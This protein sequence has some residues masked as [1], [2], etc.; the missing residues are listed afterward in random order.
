MHHLIR[1][2]RPANSPFDFIH[3]LNWLDWNRTRFE[4][5]NQ[6]LVG[7]WWQELVLFFRLTL[8]L[9]QKVDVPPSVCVCVCARVFSSYQPLP[10]LAISPNFHCLS[11][12]S[13]SNRLGDS[14][15]V[16]KQHSIANDA[17][18][19]QNS[20]SVDQSAQMWK[21]NDENISQYF[22]WGKCK[23]RF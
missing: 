15:A 13:P 23:I 8:F 3:I 20:E 17:C 7:S 6:R 16:A 5:F 12:F 4:Q 22:D 10:N 11:V 21:W 19:D 9:I 14:V 18:I 1:R 2:F